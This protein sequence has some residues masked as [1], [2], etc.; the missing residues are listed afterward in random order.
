MSCSWPAVCP[1]TLPSLPQTWQLNKSTIIQPCNYTGYS[2]PLSLRNW[3]VID[4]D[5]SNGKGTGDAE[6]WAKHRPMDDEE[7]LFEQVRMT[8]AASPETAVWVYRNSIYGYPWYTDVRTILEDPEYEPWWLKFK[9]E[10]PWNA[11]KCDAVNTSLCSDY[12]HSQLQ[13]PE[14]PHPADARSGQCAAPGCDCGATTPCGFYLFNHSS[15]AVVRGQTFQDWFVHTYGS[16]QLPPHARAA[17]VPRLSAHLIRGRAHSGTCSTHSD[18]RR[19]SR[20][21]SGTTL[22][23]SSAGS[24][25]R[26]R[27]HARTWD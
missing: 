3:G 7:M 9:P 18:R 11:S 25:T 2:D 10:G 22:G 8:K 15:T 14:Y 1:G 23:M 5:W 6:G 19:S 16:A 4:F 12:Y 21:S 27:T 13:T 17:A 20:V 26:R 24:G